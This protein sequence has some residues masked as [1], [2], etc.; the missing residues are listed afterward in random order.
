MFSSFFHHSPPA[1]APRGHTQ[2]WSRFLQTAELTT[3]GS[4]ALLGPE[5][6]SQS[7]GSG[8]GRAR[9]GWVGRQ[10]EAV[11]LPHCP[12]LWPQRC[13]CESKW[14]RVCVASRVWP[15]S[16]DH[17]TSQAIFWSPSAATGCLCYTGIPSP[18][19]SLAFPKDHNSVISCL[20]AF[21]TNLLEVKESVLSK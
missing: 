4:P 1:S 19:D 11:L 20:W 14:V 15:L 9:A 16:Y 17:S 7:R 2:H 13:D 3:Q 12:E 6:T 18:K 8:A 10:T 21:T 5:G